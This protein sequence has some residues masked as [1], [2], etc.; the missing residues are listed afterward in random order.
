MEVYSLLEAR[1]LKA[2]FVFLRYWTQIIPSS[3]LSIIYVKYLKLYYK[4]SFKCLD[5]AYG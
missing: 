3:I 2:L 5:K 1:D 4:S